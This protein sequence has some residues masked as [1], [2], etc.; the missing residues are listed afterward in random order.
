MMQFMGLSK[1]D[2]PFT[3]LG[4]S[5]FKGRIKTSYLQPIVDKLIARLAA[6]KPPFLFMVGRALLV[7]SIVHGMLTHTMFIYNWPSSLLK[8]IEICIINFILNDM[9]DNIK[10]VQVAW[11]KICNPFSHDGL[12]LRSLSRLN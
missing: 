9:V 3:Y 4:V 1:C 5:I 2:F 6:W 12:G 11:N 10:L 8:H 7:K